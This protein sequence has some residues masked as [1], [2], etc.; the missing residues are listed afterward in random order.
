MAPVRALIGLALAGAAFN[1]AP[2]A[3]CSKPLTMV[4]E[5][6][7]PYVFAGADHRQTGLDLEM[8][9][10]IFK[11]AGCT[12]VVGEPMPTV[13][14]LLLFEQGKFDLMLAA[15]DIPDR[16]RF[17]R[18]TVAYRNETVGL[19]ALASRF[20][21]YRTL[22]GFEA[23]IERGTTLLAPKVGWYGPDYERHAPVLKAQG[24][25]FDFSTLNQGMRMLRARRAELI[26]GDTAA[27][28]YQ[29]RHE[30]MALRQLPFVAWSAPVHLMLSR[31][32][33]TA[34]DLAVLDAAIAR[35]EKSGELKAIRHSYGLP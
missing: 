25:L 10:A 12:L 22:G 13:R 7:P 16:H 20:E 28:W 9:Q 31:A 18:F 32:A 30:R 27:I 34:R 19:F 29:A 24:R 5:E 26:M 6:W 4:S 2:A 23:I 11:E 21:A 1:A 17:A 14:R 35:L 3:T 8:V 33:T 15:S